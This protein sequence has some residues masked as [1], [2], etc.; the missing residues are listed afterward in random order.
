MEIFYLVMVIALVAIGVVAFIFKGVNFTVFVATA[1]VIMLIPLPVFGIGT[2]I[3]KN[4][5]QTF[6]EYWN[7]YE[8]AAVADSIECVRDGSC[9]HTYDCDPYTVVELEFYTDSDGNSQTRMVTKTK[10][11]SCPY[12]KQ[13]T[14]YIVEST[15]QPFSILSSAMTGEPYRAYPPIPGGQVT[16]PPALWTEA[17][18][19]I[20]AGKPGP[21]TVVKDYKNFILASERTL[22]KRYSGQIDSLLAENLL[23]APAS[24]THNVYQANKAYFVGKEPKNASML[25]EHVAYL[26]G[27]VGDE[28]HGDL[29]VLFVDSKVADATDYSN[30]V[31]AYWQNKEAQGKNAL[32]KNAIV[33]VIGVEKYSAPKE[34]KPTEEPLDETVT[35][36]VTPIAEELTELVNPV[37]AEPVET[38]P[39]IKN[40]TPVV[41]WVKAFTGMPLGNEAMLTQIESELKGAVV[42]ETLIGNPTFDI[43]NETVVHTEGKLESILFGVNKFDRVSMTASDED[44]NGSGFNYLAEEWEPDAGTMSTIQII[45]AILIAIAFAFGGYISYN[46]YMVLDPVRDFAL[47]LTRKR[48]TNNGVR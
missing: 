7:G 16:S 33:V 19:R 29:H 27:A 36:P 17:K 23:V 25:A 34:N 30:S 39:A 47:I 5:Q 22:F 6:H 4:D 24:G 28:L 12:S 40:G 13:E 20:E 41:G 31:L 35:E 46:S 37:P 3:A 42:D 2:A 38:T 10:Y 44:D 9:R 26:N 14:T 32:S 15:I 11:H 21:V 45:S 1:A 43:K 48:K 18:N 8:T